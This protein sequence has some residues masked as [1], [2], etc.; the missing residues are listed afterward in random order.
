M[1]PQNAKYLAG[2]KAEINQRNYEGKLFLAVLIL[3]LLP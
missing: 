3:P 1:V 2:A